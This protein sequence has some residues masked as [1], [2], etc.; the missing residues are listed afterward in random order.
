MSWLSGHLQGTYD[1]KFV[2]ADPDVSFEGD[3][4]IKAVSMKQVVEEYGAERL[5]ALRTAYEA[6]SEPEV[7]SCLA[8]TSSV[9][10]AI[11]GRGTYTKVGLFSCNLFIYFSL[12]HTRSNICRLPIASVYLP[13]QSSILPPTYRYIRSSF[14]SIL[15]MTS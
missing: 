1:L 8:N 4:Y 11:G 15:M 6:L 2:T 5:D 7:P 12:P 10:T 13:A 9:A 14:L 3:N